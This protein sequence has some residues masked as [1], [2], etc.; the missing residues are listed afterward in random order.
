MED[1]FH[2]YKVEGGWTYIGRA[3]T[4]VIDYVVRNEKAEE[5]IRTVKEG[6][7]TESDHILLEVEIEGPWRE[8]IVTQSDKIEVEKSVWTKAGI[9]QYHRNCTGWTCAQEETEE[10]WKEIKGKIQEMITKEKRTVIPWPMGRRAWHSKE[11][12]QKRET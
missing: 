1:H 8:K 3:G 4:S 5:E 10:L 12:K 11:W 7:R 9:E 6:N 2:L